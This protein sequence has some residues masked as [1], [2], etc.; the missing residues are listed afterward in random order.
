MP[1]INNDWLDFAVRTGHEAPSD[2]DDASRGS[3]SKLSVSIPGVLSVSIL[4]NPIS[5]VTCDIRRFKQDSKGPDTWF[6]KFA[7]WISR[8]VG[9]N[10]IIL[11]IRML[12]FSR[13]VRTIA[14]SDYLLRH[15]CT[16][17]RPH[18]ITGLPLDGFS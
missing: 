8:I 17:V 10:A 7:F 5:S 1:R 12:Y 18:I 13:R 14:K 9:H 3:V 2:A 16:S 4:S 6:P 15:F 11:R